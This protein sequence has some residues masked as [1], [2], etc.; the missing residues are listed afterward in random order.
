M[1]AKGDDRKLPEGTAERG[2]SVAYRNVLRVGGKRSSCEQGE[3]NR[4][5]ECE[6]ST[7]RVERL[8]CAALHVGGW[9]A[10]LS[11][12]ATPQGLWCLYTMARCCYAFLGESVLAAH[13]WWA[14][15]LTSSITA[16]GSVGTFIPFAKLY[17]RRYTRF[18]GMR[19]QAE[20]SHSV[21]GFW[22][23][24]EVRLTIGNL[25]VAAAL[26]SAIGVCH[27]YMRDTRGQ[28]LDRIYFDKPTNAGSWFYLLGSTVFFFLWID[29]WAYTAHRLLHFPLLYK[30][31]HKVH[32]TFKQ[33]TAFSALG[34]HPF[35]ML[36]LQGGIYVGLY[37]APLHIAAVTANLLYIHYHNVVDHSG[38]YCE[39]WLPWQPSSL[40]HDDHHRF[41]HANYGQSLT[42]WDRL[43]GTLYTAKKTYNEQSFS[44]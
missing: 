11:F 15:L 23:R 37:V 7:A 25:V 32:H 26:V 34:L 24:L 14:W 13:P 42:L 36:L 6:S 29:L 10:V 19:C 4:G 3:C 8:G 28:A 5:Q 40:Y 31:T 27:I 22:S 44:W 20:K 12:F 39:S 17:D 2:R 38:M 21:T 41:F 35:D 1:G 9:L 18:P 33:P 30:S 16:C 43:G